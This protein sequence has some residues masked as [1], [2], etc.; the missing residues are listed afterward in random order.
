MF[1]ELQVR[2]D[3][4]KWISQGF[5]RIRTERESV[6]PSI[7]AAKCRSKVSRPSARGR[8]IT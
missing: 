6:G 5:E 3:V 4:R 1:A 8:E 2:P 7:V